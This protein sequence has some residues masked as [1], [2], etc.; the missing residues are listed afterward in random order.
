MKRKCGGGK[1]L[2]LALA[3]TKIEEDELKKIKKGSRGTQS[4]AAHMMG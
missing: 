4:H 2:G 3:R 1:N